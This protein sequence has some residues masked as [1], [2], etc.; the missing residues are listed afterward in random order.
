MTESME[1]KAGCYLVIRIRGGVKASREVLETLKMLNLPRANYAVF[2]SKNPGFE[3]MLKKVSHY[4][5]W[6]E[7]SYLTVK[8]L[9]RRAEFNGR[10]RLSN[11]NIGKLGYSSI[12]ELAE[13]IFRG[14]ITL[15][16]LRDRG[17]KPYLRLHPPR[18]GFRKTIK[19]S[20]QEGGEH[21][22]RGET[23]NELAIRMS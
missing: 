19:K 16:M 20:Y 13:K 4:I 12:D 1:S 14:E 18:K 10:I 8:R 9:L 23:V 22:Y 15:S 2:V 21:G 11:E 17:L 5:T 3:G 6:G 7:P